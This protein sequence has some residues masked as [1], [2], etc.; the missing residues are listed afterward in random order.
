MAESIEEKLYNKITELFPGSLCETCYLHKPGT[1][2]RADCITYGKRLC[3]RERDIVAKLPNILE[4]AGYVKLPPD[5][6]VLE[7]IHHL[8]E[9][10]ESQYE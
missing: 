1:Y 3:A 8:K 4:E 5:S 9:I 6:A 2:T 7:G 10:G